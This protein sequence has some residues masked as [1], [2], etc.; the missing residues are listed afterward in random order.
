MKK[1]NSN[2]TIDGQSFSLGGFLAIARH[3]RVEEVPRYVEMI[4]ASLPKLPKPCKAR[5]GKL[6]KTC[7]LKPDFSQNKSENMFI[8]LTNPF[9]APY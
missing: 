7:G 8:K 1:R 6:S 4:P 5:P 3:H 9:N 2:H